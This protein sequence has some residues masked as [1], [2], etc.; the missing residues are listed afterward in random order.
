M[1]GTDKSRGSV[2]TGTAIPP[3]T[4]YVA[5]I[6]L[7]DWFAGQALANSAICTGSAPNYELDRWFGGRGGIT[8]A[9]IV[10]LQAGQYADAMLAE[11]AKSGG[12]P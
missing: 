5:G 7:R 12:A 10:A 2:F 9:E 4:D 8:K 1:M 11:R 3:K 6:L